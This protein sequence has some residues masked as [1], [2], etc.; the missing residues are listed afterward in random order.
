MYANE[1]VPV[2]PVSGGGN[3]GSD[4]FGGNGGFGWIFAFLIIAIIFGAG[5]WNGNNRNATG[6]S[7]MSAALPLI[8]SSIGG[9]GGGHGCSTAIADGFALNNL[10]G[11]INAIQ[12]GICDSTYGITNTITSGFNSLQAQLAGCCCETG[13]AIEG[14]NYNIAKGLCDIGNLIQTSTRDT[15]DAQNAGTRAILDFLTNDKIETLRSENQALKFAASQAAQN[16]FITANQDAQT[17]ELIRRLGRDVPVPAYMVPNPNCCY[18]NNNGN[19]GC[20]C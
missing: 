9:N 5:N 8:V 14:V 19:C 20:N 11:G 6:D 10:Q 4:V 15:I 2:V 7:G 13:R 16:A 18:G 1:A 17:A 12:R 3:S